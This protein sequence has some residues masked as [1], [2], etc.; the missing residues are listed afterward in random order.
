MLVNVGVGGGVT[1]AV[2]DKVFECVQVLVGGMLRVS[3]L[4]PV[5]VI[6]LDVEYVKVKVG[7]G[8]GVTVADCDWLLE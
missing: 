6:E 8:G 2:T 1:V 7:V 3:D 4:D 5:P